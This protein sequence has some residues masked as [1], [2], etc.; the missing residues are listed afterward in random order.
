MVLL[1][2]GSAVGINYYVD[3]GHVFSPPEYESGIVEILLSGT[4]VANLVDYNDRLVHKLLIQSADQPEDVVAIGSSRILALNSA[5]FSGLSFRNHGL[6]SG[7][8]QDQ[9]AVIELYRQRKHFPPVVILGMD[10]W[11][12]NR[13]SKQRRWREL[14]PEVSALERFLDTSGDMQHLDGDDSLRKVKEMFSITY[15]KRAL[16]QLLSFQTPRDYFPT[17]EN[18]GDF[19]ILR[20][21]GSMAYEKRLRE[22]SVEAVEAS[23]LALMSRN[24]V[25]TLEKFHEMDPWAMRMM[26]VMVSF[27]TERSVKV[28]LYLPLYHPSAYRSLIANERTRI[29]LDVEAHYLQLGETLGVPVV[30]S[31]D[32]GAVGCVKSEFYDAVHAKGS[33]IAKIFSSLSILELLRNG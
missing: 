21:D 6:M 26:G 3:P 16:V 33:C 29:V 7:T 10:P 8:L 31:F 24:P 9:M 2:L 17:N 19:R 25:P 22:L 14:S 28:V 18:E 13:N 11:L 27:L 12:L 30:G 20:A 32:P 5:L 15:F 23:A 4:N 1:G